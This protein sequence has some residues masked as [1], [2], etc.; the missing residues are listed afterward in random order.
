[1][2]PT[3]RRQQ[4]ALFACCGLAV[5]SCETA[6]ETQALLIDPKL[7]GQ[8]AEEGR[9]TAPNPP[10]RAASKIVPP[11]N[12]SGPRPVFLSALRMA[13][14][15]GREFVAEGDAELRRVGATINANLMTYWPLEDEVEAVGRVRLQHEDDVMTGPK[16]RLRL[17]DR[18]G[19]FEQPSYEIKHQSLLGKQRIS[20][21]EAS[22]RKIGQL[23]GNFPVP[24]RS[25]VSKMPDENKIKLSTTME[26]RGE[27]ERLYFEGENHYRLENGTFT[28][29][30]ADN[31]SWYVRTSNL[32]LDYDEEVGKGQNAI[33]YF[34][35]VPFLYSPWMSF[36]LNSRRKSGFL[37]PSLGTRSDNGFEFQLPYYWNI[38]PNRDAT[39]T[40]RLMS[41]RGVQLA[42]E[43]RYLNTALG[44]VYRGQMT[45]EYL[46]GDRLRNGKNRHGFSLMHDQTSGNGF[47]GTIN[48]SK[49]SDDDYYTDLSS[50]IAVTSQ[51]QL[52][53]QGTLAYNSAWW[54]ASLNMQ[55]YQTLQPDKDDPVLEQ[56]RML[57]QFTFNARKPD[58]YGADFNFFGQYTRF[59]IRQR[60]QFGTIFPDGRRT[61]LYP[62]ISLPYVKPGWYITPKFGVNYRQYSLSGQVRGDPGSISIALP[63]L[64]LDSGMTFERPSRWFG[65]N[66]TQTLEPR[67]YYV[68]IP[69]KDQS[70]IPLFDTALADF[71]FAQIFSE[72]QFSGQDRINNAKQLTVAL[73]SR[74]IEPES[75]QEI[76]RAMLGQRFYFSRNKVALSGIVDDNSKK[77]DRSD[78]LAG[79]GGQIL[80]KVFVD[81]AWQFDLN[82]RKTKRYSVEMRYRPEPGKVLNAAYRLYRETGAPINQIDISGQWPLGGRWYGV[83]R[84]NYSFKDDSTV[85]S[86]GDRGGRIIE[87]IAGLEYNGGCWILRGVIRRQ[88]LTSAHASNSF[89]VQLELSGLGRIGTNPINLL[90]RSVPGYGLI[91]GDSESVFD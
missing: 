86:A 55:Q 36:S 58:V 51:A 6:A 11:Q 33:L 23:S 66:Y 40:P 73:T 22:D 71:N 62:Q 48:F 78:V 74:L 43:Y 13:G 15:T 77:W 26:S 80:P 52:L 70:K 34:K 82:N 17:E 57:P 18:V 29:C 50:D 41:R 16:L 24:P 63:I 47:S 65:R 64:T 31:D 49:V 30:P 19:Y 20:E 5:F 53:Q 25:F 72:N 21:Q 2:N 44:G 84:L 54:S 27:A 38:A 8:K 59:N 88:A 76:M 42:S 75:G 61:V 91:G 35:D 37:R 9:V 12:I 56:Y 81:T 90:K 14:E 89:F 10:L 32:K 68:D 79:F 83:G 67:L 69:Y 85:L 1:M 46:P 4:I 87:S 7:L 60:Q 28:T 3:D 39:I 45:A